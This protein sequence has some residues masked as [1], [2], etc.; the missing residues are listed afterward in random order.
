M[1]PEQRRAA[2]ISATLP[3][4]REFG[5]NV[6]TRQVAEASGVAKGTIFRVFDSLQDLIEATIVE[7]FSPRQLSAELDGVDL[8]PT[9]AEKALNALI[10]IEDRITTTRSLLVVAHGQERRP[11][12]VNPCIKDEL[13][14]RRDQLETWLCDAFAVHADELVCPVRDFVTLLGLIAT[15]H[16]MRLG[17]TSVLSLDE[18]TSLALNGALRK[19][20]L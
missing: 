13:N 20:H 14:A 17:A 7:A 8:G 3:L 16:A 15:G 10:L 2:I 1:P 19:D 5:P 18:L 9:L 6:T 11:H 12:A 4:V